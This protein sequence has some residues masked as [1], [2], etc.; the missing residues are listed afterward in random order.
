[1][2]RTMNLKLKYHEAYVLG[3]WVQNPARNLLEQNYLQDPYFDTWIL[4]TKSVSSPLKN[5]IL[6]LETKI[7][8]W[9]K[10]NGNLRN[11]RPENYYFDISKPSHGHQFEAQN[12]NFE[13]W[14]ED[15][16]ISSPWQDIRIQ[17]SKGRTSSMGCS[18]FV[19]YK[20]KSWWATVSVLDRTNDHPGNRMLLFRDSAWFPSQLL[21]W[22]STANRSSIRLSRIFLKFRLYG[23]VPLT[24]HP[25]SPIGLA[26]Q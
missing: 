24:F 13:A 22:K 3:S 15:G 9:S 4:P 25:L 16:S 19:F 2:K 10:I 1:M 18:I 12:S 23:L 7:Q 17:Q 5:Y 21:A 8:I 6:F 14:I 11:Q 26:V 20:K